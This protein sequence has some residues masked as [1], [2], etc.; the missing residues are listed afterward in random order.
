MAPLRAAIRALALV[1][2]VLGALLVAACGGGGD[3][4]EDRVQGLAP[5]EI[6]ERS[7]EAADAATGYRLGLQAQLTATPAANV[8]LGGLLAMLVSGP[9]T[10]DAEG[11]VRRPDA[12]SLDASIMLGSGLQAQANITKVAGDLYISAFGQD[13]RLDLPPEQVEAVNPADLVPALLGWMADPQ[14]V[15]RESV[16]GVQTVLLRGG[17]SPEAVTADLGGLS[18]ELGAGPLSAA[19]RARAQ[20]Q[21]AASLREGV[22]EVWVAVGDLLPRRMHARI[23]L[24]GRVD[25]VPQFEALDL[26]ATLSL[27]DWDDVGEI[28]PPAGAR[29]IDPDSLTSLIG[30]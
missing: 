10:L 3:G 8:R 29:T 14:E 9:V 17:I 2:L 7:R 21:L 22:V 19:D 25:A 27:S 26:D 20:R 12:A 6:L 4:D 15:S 24:A 23:A 1:A 30:G 5:A 11:P 18:G 28:T 13:L 16:D